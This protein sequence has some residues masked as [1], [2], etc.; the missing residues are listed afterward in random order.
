MSEQGEAVKECFCCTNKLLPYQHGFRCFNVQCPLVTVV[1]V[2][3]SYQAISAK[4]GAGAVPEV[5]DEMAYAF[6]AALADGSIDT[7]EVEDIKAGLRAAL[8]NTAKVNEAVSE[9]LNKYADQQCPCD[10][11][12]NYKDDCK[13][14]C[15][16]RTARRSL[17][18]S[19]EILTQA[20]FKIESR[21]I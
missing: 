5:T 9:K 18:E 11:N 12:E 7:N 20:I 8:C 15:A 17:N 10:D 3:E 2:D 13:I 1:F 14:E 16:S 19:H 4:L 6:H 21:R